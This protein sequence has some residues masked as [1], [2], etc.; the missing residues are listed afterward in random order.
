M[1][2]WDKDYKTGR[3]V[4]DGPEFRMTM[5][6]SK[7]GKRWSFSFTKVVSKEVKERIRGEAGWRGGK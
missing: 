1:A 5:K 3:T 6:P 7:N 4:V 2:P